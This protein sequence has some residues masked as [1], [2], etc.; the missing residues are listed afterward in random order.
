[1]QASR[2]SASAQ[3]FSLIEISI[4]VGVLGVLMAALLPTGNIVL[5]KNRYE[6]T[7]AKLDAIEEAIQNFYNQRGYLPC[8]ASR[9]ESTTSVEYGKS[10]DCSTSPAGITTVTPAAPGDADDAIAIGFLP[11]RM[12]GLPDTHMFDAW[13]QRFTYAVIK[14]LAIDDSQFSGYSTAL[15]TGVLRINNAAGAQIPSASTSTVVAYAIVSHGPDKRGAYT[16]ANALG[17]ACGTTEKDTENC[18]N[19]EVS[20]DTAINETSGANYFYDFIRW[21]LKSTIEEGG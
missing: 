10:V 5:E 19:D 18:D 7:D 21:Q 14:E 1:M 15:T 20:I 17:I 9:N 16:K 13:D 6:D 3:G 8:P 11:T 4:L 12:L 2:L